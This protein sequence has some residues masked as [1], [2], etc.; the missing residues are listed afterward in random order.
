MIYT[1]AL[2]K[3]VINANSSEEIASTDGNGPFATN[4]AGCADGNYGMYVNMQA[5]ASRA[6][7][8][9]EPSLHRG[10]CPGTAPALTGLQARDSRQIL[11]YLRIW[12]W[13]ARLISLASV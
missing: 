13:N 4:A 11:G 12:D 3:K 5:L 2:H 9:A 10:S 8:T 1:K 6:N 7:C